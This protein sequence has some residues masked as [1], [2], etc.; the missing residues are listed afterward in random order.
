MHVQP[1]SIEL[2]LPAGRE[3]HAVARLVLGGVADRLNLSF[4]DLDDLQLAVERLLVEAATQDTIDLRIDVVDHGIRVGVGPLAERT[5][6]EAL[7]GPDAE[8]GELTLR[9]ILQTVVDSFGV[10]EHAEGGIVVRLQ[11]TVRG[12]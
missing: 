11:K 7:Q 6:A 9:R 3:W 4:E 10:E 8:P 2:T 12:R 1:E 5:I